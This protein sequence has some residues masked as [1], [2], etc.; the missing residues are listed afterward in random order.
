M[1]NGDFVINDF[2]ESG[3]ML[4]MVLSH[5]QLTGDRP[6]ID[7]Y[8]SVPNSLH[9]YGPIVLFSLY[10]SSSGQST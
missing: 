2:T 5:Y 3:D 4:I 10:S 1:V 8:V 6:L 7:S 9:N